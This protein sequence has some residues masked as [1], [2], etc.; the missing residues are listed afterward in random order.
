MVRETKTCLVP[1]ET[2]GVT[3]IL[4]W[5]DRNRRST[6][7]KNVTISPTFRVS[8]TTE[9][10]ISPEPFDARPASD[11]KRILVM[12]SSCTSPA[13]KENK[14]ICYKFWNE[15]SITYWSITNIQ[16]LHHRRKLARKTSIVKSLRSQNLSSQLLP[17]ILIFFPFFLLSNLP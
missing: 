3:I 11:I 17:T 2:S 14:S 10:G 5:Q 9:Y 8:L 7:H 13:G 1:L 15:T 6:C 12:A 4:L 16:R